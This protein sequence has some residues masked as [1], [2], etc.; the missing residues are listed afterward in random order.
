MSKQGIIAWI[1]IV[2]T[3]I[4]ISSIVYPNL[5][6]FIPENVKGGLFSIGVGIFLI[7]YSKNAVKYGKQTLAAFGLSNL[8]PLVA[9]YINITPFL[10]LLMG[11]ISLIL[12]LGVLFG[13]IPTQ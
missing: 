13:L 7:L 4:I 1:I 11:I 2:E 12:G 10:F 8:P 5:Y 9:K 6:D 3:I